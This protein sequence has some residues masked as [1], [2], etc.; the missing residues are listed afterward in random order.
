VADGN[1]G[2]VVRG[3]QPGHTGI[4]TIMTPC[5]QSLFAGQYRTICREEEFRGHVYITVINKGGSALASAD[6]IC[7]GQPIKHEAGRRIARLRRFN[8]QKNY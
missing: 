5:N 3:G 7:G 8:D 4:K 1:G 2:L 6:A